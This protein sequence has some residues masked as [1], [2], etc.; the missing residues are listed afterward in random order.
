MP[1][2][3]NGPVFPTMQRCS[4]RP[5]GLFGLWVAKVVFINALTSGAAC[6][7]DFARVV[8]ADVEGV[9]NMCVSQLLRKGR[10][11]KKEGYK[12]EG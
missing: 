4:P 1:L 12:A 6:N 5:M 10:K 7:D 2:A 9:F 11:N 3:K 8:T